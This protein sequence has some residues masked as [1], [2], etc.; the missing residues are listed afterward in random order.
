MEPDVEAARAVFIG[1]VISS[2]VTD[3]T[4]RVDRVYKGNI[5]AELVMSAGNGRH[6]NG[7]IVLSPFAYSF[8]TGEHYLV[9]ANGRSLARITASE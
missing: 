8:S 7:T 2:T 4:F 6:P 3:V 1:E 9:F 5:G